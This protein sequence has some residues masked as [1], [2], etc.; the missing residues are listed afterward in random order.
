MIVYI[1]KWGLVLL[2]VVVFNVIDVC[3]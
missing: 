3:N 2:F 1:V